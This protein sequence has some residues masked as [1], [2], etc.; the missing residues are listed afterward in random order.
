VPCNRFSLVIYFIHSINCICVTI[1]ISQ[2]LPLPPLLPSYPYICFLCLWLYF[3][4]ANKTHSS[5]LAWRIPGTEEP[6]GLPSMGSHG[7]RHDLA[8]AAA[9][10]KFYRFHIYALTDDIY[11]SLFDSPHSVCHS[12]GLSTSIQMCFCSFFG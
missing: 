12:L 9:T 1:P 3:C 4:F 8:A 5:V 6:G 2:F 7:D 10:H 11:F